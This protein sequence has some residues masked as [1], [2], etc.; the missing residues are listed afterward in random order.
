[1]VECVLIRASTLS[2]LH[3][4]PHAGYRRRSTHQPRGHILHAQH[5]RAHAH[6][7]LRAQHTPSHISHTC[8]LVQ[9]HAKDSARAKPVGHMLHAHQPQVTC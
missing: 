8:Q 6:C 7:T 5:M 1:M 2:V 9:L 4:R 3:T